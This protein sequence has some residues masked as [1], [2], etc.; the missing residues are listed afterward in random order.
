[1]TTGI[2]LISQ[3]LDTPFQVLHCSYMQLLPILAA[4]VAS[5]LVGMAWYSPFLFGPLWMK[6]VGHKNDHA[7]KGEYEWVLPLLASIFSAFLIAAVLQQGLQQGKTSSQQMITVILMLWLLFC[8]GLRLPNYLHE[9]RSL[10]LF[11]IYAGHDLVNLLAIGS[12]V[13]VWR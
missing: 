5:L 1:M 2:I 12:I 10:G 3:Q 9:K 6:Q 4:I 8:V 13:S 11:L 7:K